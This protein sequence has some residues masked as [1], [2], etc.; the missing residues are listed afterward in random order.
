MLLVRK[1]MI[2]TPGNPKPHAGVR[3]IVLR[4]TEDPRYKN[5]VGTRIS[6]FYRLF[7][8]KEKTE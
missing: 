7:I 3:I 6:Y 5:T 1:T 4:T 8:L 2:R